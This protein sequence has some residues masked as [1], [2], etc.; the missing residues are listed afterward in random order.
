VRR[1]SAGNSY[2]SCRGNM[3][4]AE[5]TARHPVAQPYSSA[6]CIAVAGSKRQT[7]KP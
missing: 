1:E 4:G 3:T 7:S 2:P 6:A 5:A